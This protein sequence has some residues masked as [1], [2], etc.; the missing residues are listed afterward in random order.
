MRIGYFETSSGGKPGHLC[1]QAWPIS[2]EIGLAAMIY[3]F[4]NLKQFSRLSRRI[5]VHKN[6]DN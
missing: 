6:I 1:V 4:S 3:C 2:S 5:L